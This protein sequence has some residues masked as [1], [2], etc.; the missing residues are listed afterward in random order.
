M[1]V[2]PPRPPAPAAAAPKPP[3]PPAPPKPAAPAPAAAAPTTAAPAKEKAERVVKFG[4]AALPVPATV[5]G[6]NLDWVKEVIKDAT[7]ELPEFAGY[8]KAFEATAVSTFPNTAEG[9][10]AYKLAKALNTFALTINGKVRA[11]RVAGKVA[12]RVR[13]TLL[14]MVKMVGV[15][16]CKKSVSEEKWASYG[17]TAEELAA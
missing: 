8:S 10:R 17:F 7:K 1:A 14:E 15:D 6:I 4:D 11:P 2:P 5:G 3:G 16:V 12:D 13:A 9:K